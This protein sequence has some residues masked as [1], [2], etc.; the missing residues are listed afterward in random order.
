MTADILNQLVRDGGW[1]WIHLFDN[2]SRPESIEQIRESVTVDLAEANIELLR[3]PNAGI[4]EMW[5][6]GW[7]AACSDVE[8]PV[9]VA[10]LNNDIVIPE[11]G[12]LDTLRHALRCEPDIW[13]VY[14]DYRMDVRKHPQ[15]R[16]PIILTPTRGTYQHGGMCGWAFMIRGEAPLPRIDERFEWWYGDDDLV[17]NI[18]ARGKKVCR[19]N[20][21]PLNHRN[22]ATANNGENEWTHGAKSRDTKRFKEKWG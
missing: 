2:G 15:G 11:V 7:S 19:V 5:N 4:Y 18:T 14:P 20:G 13:A 16:L 1:D 6:E 9:N 22:E 12:F 8:G 17:R 3:R 10:I 21:L